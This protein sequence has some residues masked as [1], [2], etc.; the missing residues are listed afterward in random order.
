MNI[1]E[2]LSPEEQ[3]QVVFH[4]LERNETL[5]HENDLCEAIGIV[6]RGQIDI[7]SYLENGREILFNSLGPGGIF[8]NNL[9]FSSDRRYKG[10]I[11]AVEDCEVALIFKDVLLDIIRQNS[12]FLEEYLKIQSDFSKRLNERIRLL[13]ISSARERFLYYLHA[14]HNVIR[15]DAIGK[16]AR[17]LFLSREALSR[18]LSELKKENK[19]TRED[20][21]IRLL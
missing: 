4:R 5:F 21:V 15:F 10:D 6:I 12:S 20:K 18:L 2:L 3:K 9:L 16:L 17:E 14:R 19:I 13:S 1:I 8:G 11:V 7:V